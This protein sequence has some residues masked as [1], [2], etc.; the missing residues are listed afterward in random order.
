[1]TNL[2]AIQFIIGTNA[3]VSLERLQAAAQFN[4]LDHAGTYNAEDQ[5]L[6]C[7]IYKLALS[8]LQK[9]KGVASETEGGYSITYKDNDKAVFALIAAESGCS[10]LIAEFT[11]RPKVK[12]ASHFW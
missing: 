7:R 10:E 1:M 5:T 6:K 9:V 2:Q 12:D 8:E 4:G 3:D 11:F